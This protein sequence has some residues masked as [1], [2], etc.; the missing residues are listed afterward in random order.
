MQVLP[1]YMLITVVR[2]V[3]RSAC[4]SRYPPPS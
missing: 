4:I 2:P 1:T 3:Y